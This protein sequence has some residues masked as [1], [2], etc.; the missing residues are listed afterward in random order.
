MQGK[1]VMD[2]TDKTLIAEILRTFNEA[3]ARSNL[4]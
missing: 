2:V 4:E 1:S 3:V